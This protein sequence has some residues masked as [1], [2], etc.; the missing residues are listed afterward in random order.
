MKQTIIIPDVIIH[1]QLS[2]TKVD[3]DLIITI[4]K[5]NVEFVGKIDRVSQSWVIQKKD[6]LE[7]LN[8]KHNKTLHFKNNKKVEE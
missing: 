8:T 6:L 7:I 4:S 3:E 1:T 5:N 2:N